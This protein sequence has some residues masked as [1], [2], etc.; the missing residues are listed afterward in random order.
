[1]YNISEVLESIIRNGLTTTNSKIEIGDNVLDDND[2]YSFEI[3]DDLGI[4]GQPSIG[5]AVSKTMTLEIV[6]ES[7]SMVLTG[8]AIKVSLGYNL[9]ETEDYITQE[10][11]V[12][13][14]PMGVFYADPGTV[15]YGEDRVTVE[16]YDKM[17]Y[18]DN[19]H[20]A[21]MLAYP[22]STH[23]MLEEISTLT[24]VAIENINQI[25]DTTWL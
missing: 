20:Y 5:S 17:Y 4:D 6:P 11:E 15:Q 23:D 1:M 16:C 12:E 10:S 13:Y 2:I 25:A 18:W 21:T 7:A 24:G 14:I 19:T 22:E 9:D 3:E 8:N